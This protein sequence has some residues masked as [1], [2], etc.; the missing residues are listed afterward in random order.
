MVAEII[1]DTCD[2]SEIPNDEWLADSG[3]CRHICNDIRMLWNVRKLD[4]PVIVKQ[5]VG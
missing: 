5:L 1:V 4:L 2:V 3:A